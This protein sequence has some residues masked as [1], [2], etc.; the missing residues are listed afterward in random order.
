MGLFNW[1]G[2]EDAPELNLPDVPQYLTAD[3]LL[4]FGQ[5]RGEQYTPLALGSREWALDIMQDPTK[6]TEYYQGFAPTSLEAALANQQFS[7]LAGESDR[8]ISHNLSLSG[9]ESSPLL[10]Q[11]KTRARNELG[12]DIGSILAQLGQTR[13]TMGLQSSYNIDPYAQIIGPLGEWQGQ[14]DDQQ[15][16]ADYANAL[17]QTQIDYQ[18]QMEEYQKMMARSQR[19]G[20]LLGPIAG[21]ITG[22]WEG[23]TDSLLSTGELLANVFTGGM[24]GGGGGGGGGSFSGSQ[25]NPF[26]GFSQGNQPGTGIFGSRFGGQTQSEILGQ[27]TQGFSPVYFG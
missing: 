9:M 7:N 21:G 18:T 11:Q 16:Q 19:A 4:D 2:K 6:A 3:Q 20:S 10:A 12:V 24:Y 14:R 25:N 27:N 1:F 8:N 26:S 23:A 13:G 15:K 5:S 22:G 17:A